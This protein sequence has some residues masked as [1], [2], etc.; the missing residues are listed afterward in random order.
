MATYDTLT[1]VFNRSM[2]EQLLDIEIKRAKRYGHPMS[3]ILTDIDHFKPIKDNL[4]HSFDDPVLEK[5]ERLREE[6][7]AQPLV[8]DVSITRSFGVTTFKRD[9]SAASLFARIDQALY[10]AKALNRKHVQLYSFKHLT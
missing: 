10:K 1:D 4:G 6:I 5:A 7:S 3:I 2:F 8:D 9:D